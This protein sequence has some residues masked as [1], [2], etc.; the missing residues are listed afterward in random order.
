MDIKHNLRSIL[1]TP[2]D[3]P[4]TA[5]WPRVKK[6]LTELL[7]K[8]SR[9]FKNRDGQERKKLERESD[10]LFNTTEKPSSWS[11][12]HKQKLSEVEE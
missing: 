2:E 8:K 12:S 6:A 1:K 7:V 4:I 11:T 3:E 5:E 9:W 10:A